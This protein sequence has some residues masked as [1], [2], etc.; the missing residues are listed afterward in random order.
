M[1]DL[2]PPPLF[3][4]ADAGGDAADSGGVAITYGEIPCPVVDPEI[5]P[6]HIH[7]EVDPGPDMKNAQGPPLPDHEPNKLVQSQIS[8]PNANRVSD[9]F[10]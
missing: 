4:P 2:N 1:A 9:S 5:V 7:L 8:L 6:C 10:V 3:F